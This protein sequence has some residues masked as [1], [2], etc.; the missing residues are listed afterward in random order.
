[1]SCVHCGFTYFMT[2]C[3][4]CNV[5]YYCNYCVSVTKSCDPCSQLYCNNCK[6]YSLDKCVICNSKFC[7]YCVNNHVNNTDNSKCIHCILFDQAMETEKEQTNM[8]VDL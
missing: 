2:P 8:E 1:M 3:L 5:N 6:S 4:V 7:D